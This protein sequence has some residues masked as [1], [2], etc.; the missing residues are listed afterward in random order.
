MTDVW[1][2]S[3]KSSVQHVPGLPTHHVGLGGCPLSATLWLKLQGGQDPQR[4]PLSVHIIARA[5]GSLR[6]CSGK[7]S[8]SG[9]D[10]L[11]L[12]AVL[13]CVLSKF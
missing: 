2:L 5:Y 10:V 12:L 13:L 11:A 1:W 8:S 9:R 7:F 3:H 6:C 4:M